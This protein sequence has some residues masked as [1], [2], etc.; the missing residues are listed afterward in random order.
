[1]ADCEDG[2]MTVAPTVAPYPKRSV[3]ARNVWALSPSAYVELIVAGIPKITVISASEYV[4]Q[5]VTATEKIEQIVT[6]TEKIEQI[7]TV[8]DSI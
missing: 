5:V 4:T 1:V 8:E 2:A 3:L 6:A 7:V